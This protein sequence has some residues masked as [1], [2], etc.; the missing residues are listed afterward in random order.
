MTIL[1][2]GATG[3]TGRPL[4]STLSARGVDVRPATRATGFDWNT[5]ATW[6]S[7]LSGVDAV[8]LVETDQGGDPVAD[9]SSRAAARG[10]RRVVLLS[11]LSRDPVNTAMKRES[12]RAVAESG[13][14]WTVLRPAWFVQNLTGLSF[15]A[16]P[17]ATTGVLALPCGDGREAFIDAR[18]IAEVA[19]T[20]L[21]DDGHA[22]QTYELTGPRA[23]SFGE[24]VAEYAAAT[25]KVLRFED[26]AEEQYARQAAAAGFGDDEV[27]LVLSLFREIRRSGGA[28]IMPDVARVLGR[29]P[30]DPAV[31]IGEQGA[32][33][34]A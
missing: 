2:L 11:A 15:I 7:A 30:R 8:Y 14:A 13:V 6:D 5:P 22:G 33:A 34:A 20:A 26:I 4:V 19:A 31:W 32:S 24:L 23:M 16:E 28:P 9:F 25:G 18:D 27:A 21:L 10:V 29:A 17:L 12:E 3:K 1:V